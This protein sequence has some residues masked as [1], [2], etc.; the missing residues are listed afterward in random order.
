MVIHGACE[1]AVQEQVAPEGSVRTSTE[2]ALS[3][4]EVSTWVVVTKM[5]VQE[6]GAGAGGVTTVGAAGMQSLQPFLSHP[7]IHIA[8]RSSMVITGTLLIW[9]LSEQLPESLLGYSSY[10]VLSCQP[11]HFICL[12]FY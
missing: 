8:P 2:P 4:Y 9:L 7:P 12:T 3:R 10:K 6:G 11:P 1:T 5:Y